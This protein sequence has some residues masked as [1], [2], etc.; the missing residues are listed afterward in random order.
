MAH[1]QIVTN[2]FLRLFAANYNTIASTSATNRRARSVRRSLMMLN[3]ASLKP[4]MFRMV[5]TLASLNR[6][7]QLEVDASQLR[8]LAR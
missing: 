5:G 3:T 8:R 4:P 2:P 6:L 7:V 1:F